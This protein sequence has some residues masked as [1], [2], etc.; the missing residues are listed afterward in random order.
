MMAVRGVSQRRGRGAA[1]RAPPARVGPSSGDLVIVSQALAELAE[2]LRARQASVNRGQVILDRRVTPDRRHADGGD[3]RGPQ[4]DRRQGD[5]R[6][7]A[8]EP[9]EALMRVLGFMVVPAGGKGR[10]PAKRPA[11]GPAYRAAGRARPPA[12]RRPGRSGRA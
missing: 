11:R 1:R 9:A 8:P 6:R 7:P 5:R 2:F 10:G 3:G 4:P 12:P